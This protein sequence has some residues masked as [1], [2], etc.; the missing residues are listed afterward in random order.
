MK[1]VFD[2]FKKKWVIQLIGII[3]LGLL[4][5]F[6][7]PLIS[8]AGKIPL[9]TE[10][11][12]LIAILLIVML[13]VGYQLFVQ[14]RANR[15]NAQMVN[16]LTGSKAFAEASQ[17]NLESAEEVATLNQNFDAALQVLKQGK[18]KSGQGRQ[19]L[20]QLGGSP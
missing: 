3:A 19:Y 4:I 1:K 2:F 15:A 16:E 20:Y 6:F 10:L 13:W 5:W 7:G 11:S 8:I 18:N 9:E 12:R 17:I 14:I